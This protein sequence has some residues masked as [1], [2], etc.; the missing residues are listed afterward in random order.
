MSPLLSIC[1]TTFNRADLLRRL[2]NSVEPE[3]YPKVEFV[4]ADDGSSDGTRAVVDAFMQTAGVNVS[5]T[6]QENAGRAMALCRALRKA[7]APY[8]II[9]DSDDYFLPGGTEA[10]L[11]ALGALAGMAG[12]QS[13]LCGLLFGV[14]LLRPGREEVSLPPAVNRTN[15]IEARADHGISSD[16]KQVVR[17]DIIQENML[18][19]PPGCR[20]VPTS[21]LWARI[22]ERHDCL[23]VPEI[24]AVKEYLEGGMTSRILDLKTK[25]AEPMAMLYAILGRSP[26]YRSLAFR[27]RAKASRHRYALHAGS[28]RF[29]TALDLVLLPIGSLLYI[30]DKVRLAM[31]AR[32]SR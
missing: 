27:L 21:L 6:W 2:F 14:K 23:C 4:I 28:C 10:V 13:D 8:T 31:K 29:D 18:S 3:H 19:V 5:Y 7:S 30:S 22:A 9:M 32:R 26:R 11:T 20:R 12:N 1:I 15:F 16:L 24:I 25:N 17:T